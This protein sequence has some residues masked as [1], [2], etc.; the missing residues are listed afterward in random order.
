M[1]VE[2]DLS[3]REVEILRLLATGASNKE[4]ASALVIS[5]NTVKVHLRNIFAKIGA[6][7]RTE[8]TLTAMRM[9]LVEGV[10]E[11]RPAEIAAAAETQSGLLTILPEAAAQVTAL[12]APFWQSRWMV[13]VSAVLLVVV[14]SLGLMLL[15]NN[16]NPGQVTPTPSLP[17]A[18]QVNAPARWQTN[19]SLPQARSALAAATFESSLYLFGGVTSGGTTSSTLRYNIASNAWE[20]L[21]AKPTPVSEVQA[22][23]LG[24]M[25]YIPGGKLENSQPGLILEAYSP[26]QNR[27]ESLAPLPVALSGYALTAF[28][29]ALYLFGGWDGLRYTDMVYTYDPDSNRW[30][31]RGKMPSARG[32]SAALALEGRIYLVGGYDG[33]NA[34]ASVQVYYPSRERAGSPAWEERAPLPEG[35]Y[36]MGAASLANMLY[37]LGGEGDTRSEAGLLPLQYYPLGNQWTR[38]ERAPQVTGGWLALLALDT[39]LHAIGGQTPSGLSAAH[40]AYQAIYTI[41]LPSI[42]N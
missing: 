42:Q 20:E 8:A 9:G 12:P 31:A 4:I 34:L 29:G 32:F 19:L 33:Q 30:Q 6:A 18:S 25:I 16:A 24:E 17:T 5:P 22:A 27:W 7:S 39:R 23:V 2:T 28:E 3:E 36:A 10:G 21:A 26:R 40:Q 35:R 15:S 1:T 38:F 37:I 41:S 11:T 13:A 14:F